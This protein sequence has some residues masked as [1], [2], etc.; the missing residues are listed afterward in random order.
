MYLHSPLLVSVLASVWRF[1][2]V[3]VASNIIYSHNLYI[4][5]VHIKAKSRL[6]LRH[7]VS[8]DRRSDKFYIFLF[9]I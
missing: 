9:E 2:I 5:F 6:E 7:Y 4:A 3:I 1:R 8:Y